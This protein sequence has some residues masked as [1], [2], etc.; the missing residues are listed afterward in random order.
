MPKAADAEYLTEALRRSGWLREARVCNVAVMN[1]LKKQRSH[2]FRLGLSY[3]GAAADAPSSLVLK[4]GHLDGTGRPSY[5][6]RCEIAFYRDLASAIRVVPRCFEAVAASDTSTWHLL[7][8]DLTDSHFFATE[9]PLPPAPGQ[10]ESIVEAW[11]RCHAAWWGDPRLGVSVGSWPDEQWERYL[12]QGFT[13]RFANFADRFGQVM[14]PERRGL[15]ERLL[16]RAPRLLARY[17][18]RRD[19]TLSH[20][21]AHWW[22]CFL[23]RDGGGKVQLIDWEGW[24]IDT[25]TTDIAYMMAML[26]FPDMRRAIEQLLLDRYHAALLANG[27][28]GYDRRALHDDYRLSVLWLILRPI[29]QAASNIPPRVWWPNLERIMLAVDDLGCRELLS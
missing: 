28:S 27:V 2:T 3:E 11:A 13:E 16:D 17:R 10:C 8:E 9:W 25:G 15:Y 21:D 20:G 4:M 1:S 22:N 12:Q 7:L 26:W 19:L 6:N 14:P 18:A 5:A 23:P 24:S 29:E